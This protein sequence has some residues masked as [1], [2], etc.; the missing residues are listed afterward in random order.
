VKT[1]Q[2][3]PVLTFAAIG[4][5][6]QDKRATSEPGTLVIGSRNVFR[7]HVTVH[8]GTQRRATTIGDDNLFMVGSH[9]AHDVELG[10]FVTLANGVL[11]AGHVAVADHVTFGGAVAVAQHVRIGE[12]AFVAGG[13]MVERDVPPFV[14]AQGDRARVRALNKVGLRRRGFNEESIAALERAIRTILLGPGTRA[15]RI[16]SLA[17]AADPHVARLV[18]AFAARA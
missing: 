12:S 9:V 4:G 1:G 2:W 7:E 5:P 18:A 3:L 14:V 8:R 10:S 13:S 16:A 6:P 15:E 17:D 11:L